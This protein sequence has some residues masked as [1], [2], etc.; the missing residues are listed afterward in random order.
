MPEL[1]E[2]VVNAGAAPEPHGH[3]IHIGSSVMPPSL[4]MAAVIA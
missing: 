4:A 2:L 1:G 3:V